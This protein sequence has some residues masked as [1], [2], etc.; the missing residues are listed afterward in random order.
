MSN[1]PTKVVIL[2]LR[3]VY[4]QRKELEGGRREEKTNRQSKEKWKMGRG[5]KLAGQ[6]ST[7]FY[8]CNI[9]SI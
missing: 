9:P 3:F 8:T 4:I 2:L 6:G 7:L 5:T 1:I